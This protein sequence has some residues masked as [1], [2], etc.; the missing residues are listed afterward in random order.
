M[1]RPGKGPDLALAHLH[2]TAERSAPFRDPAVQR[3]IPSQALCWR[4]LPFL[5]FV[6]LTGLQGH[7]GYHSQYWLY[8][9]KTIFAAAFLWTARQRLAEMRWTFGW[10]PLAAGVVIWALWVGLDPFY[11]KLPGRAANGWNPLADFGSG[12]FEAWFLIAIRLAGSSLVVPPLEEVFYR[13]FLYRYLIQEQFDKVPLTVVRTFPFLITALIFGFS[14]F[15]WLPAILCGLIFQRLVCRQGHLG[16][17][18]AAH[19]TTN[20]LLG[21]WVVTRQAWSF[22]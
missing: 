2:Q 15:E 16:D 13:S 21:V 10:R 7:A 14:H 20:F 4:V 9:A 1:A 11:P 6:G 22:W 18:I 5:L 17:A 8:L 19:A 3:T 12:S